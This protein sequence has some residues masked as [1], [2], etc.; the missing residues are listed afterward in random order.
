MSELEPEH[1]PNQADDEYLADAYAALD[2]DQRQHGVHRRMPEAA[3]RVRLDR[4]AGAHDGPRLTERRDDALGVEA[5][6]DLLPA[7]ALS[8]E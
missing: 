5:G 2:G 6:I 8:G 4:D 7:S 3:A 1:D